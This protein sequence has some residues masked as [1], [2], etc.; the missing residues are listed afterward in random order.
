MTEFI[1]L[2]FVELLLTGAVSTITLM[3][4]KIGMQS[5]VDKMER[6]ELAK[7]MRALIG[8]RLYHSCNHYIAK[9][10]L[11]DH[12][13]RL[14]KNLYDSYVYY[15]GNGII[16][17]KFDRVKIIYSGIGYQNQ[18]GNKFKTNGR[19]LFYE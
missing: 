4:R 8:D 10:S 17:S 18:N 16:A 7:A 9:G 15:D 2:Y 12:E 19:D 1:R 6:E 11:D 3:V 14:L 13:F 5:N